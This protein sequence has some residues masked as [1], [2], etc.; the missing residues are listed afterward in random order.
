MTEEVFKIL[1]C[2]H[3]ERIARSLVHYKLL[4][5]MLPEID[6]TIRSGKNKQMTS[7]LYE[8]LK[9]L[10]QVIAVNENVTRAR[11]LAGLVDP[12]LSFPDE[13]ENTQMLFKSIFKQIKEIIAPITPPNYEVERA[14]EYFFKQQGIK[15][16]K[17]AVRKP[18][19]K[20]ARKKPQKYVKRNTKKRTPGG[21]H[22]QQRRGSAANEQQKNKS[23]AN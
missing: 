22:P 18:A 10:D 2:G 8:S 14:V 23:S 16:P 4:I 20:N 12:F 1:Q 7:E 21:Q 9:T 13:Y 17:N 6:R 11:M 15:V 3:S 5:W 19:S